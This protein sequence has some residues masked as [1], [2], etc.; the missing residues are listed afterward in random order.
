[1]R[2]SVLRGAQPGK[3]ILLEHIRRQA[4]GRA[5]IRN[6]QW[7]AAHPCCSNSW[8]VYHLSADVADAAAAAGWVAPAWPKA[9][10]ERSN[11][12]SRATEL[13][14]SVSTGDYMH[15]SN[16][17]AADLSSALL[18][19]AKYWIQALEQDAHQLYWS[20][21]ARFALLQCTLRLYEKEKLEHAFHRGPQCKQLG[22]S[23]TSVNT[24]RN[25]KAECSAHLAQCIKLKITPQKQ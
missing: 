20:H 7:G 9:R 16:L 6:G 22:I 14:Q 18:R 21:R 1:M 5:S 11:G 2:S 25:P 15:G 3:H 23:A 13:Y 17:V 4:K 19:Q 12:D 8:K 10:H 24:L